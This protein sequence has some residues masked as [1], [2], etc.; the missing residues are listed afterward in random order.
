VFDPTGV[1]NEGQRGF[2]CGKN[3]QGKLKVGKKKEERKRK[4]V[5]AD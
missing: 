2:N 5:K 1:G 3:E 4:D